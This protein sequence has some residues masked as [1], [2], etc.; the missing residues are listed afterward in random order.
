MTDAMTLPA[1]CGEFAQLETRE[2]VFGYLIAVSRA[3][4]WDEVAA[5]ETAARAADMS[6]EELRRVRDVLRRLG[7]AKVA[8]ML[9][10]LA[11]KAKPF[12]KSTICKFSVDVDLST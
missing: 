9:T 8:T 12:K 11:R 10:A 5:V 2:E 4:G 3:E 7:Y 1:D 6:R